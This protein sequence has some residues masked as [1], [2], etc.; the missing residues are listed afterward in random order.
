MQ[1]TRTQLIRVGLVVAGSLMAIGTVLFLIGQQQRL[2]ERKVEYRVRFLRTNGLQVGAPVALTGVTIGS[3][4]S[5]DFPDNPSAQFVV[6]TLSVSRRAAA[7]IKLDAT[8][9]IRTLGLLGDK[10]IELSAG[11]L[12]SPSLAPGA[13]LRAVDPVDYEAVLGQ[14]GDIVSNIIEVTSIMKSVLRAIEQGEGLLG[15]ILRN[16]EAGSEALANF[17][18]T[19]ENLERSTRALAAIAEEVEKG[20]GVLGSLLKDDEAPKEILARLDRA[21]RS[22]EEMANRLTRAQGL[23]PQLLEDEAYGHRLAG[24]L[25]RALENLADVAEKI[26]RGEGTAGQLVNDPTLYRDARKLV[27][28]TQGSWLFGLYRNLQRLW[29]FRADAE[30]HEASSTL[31]D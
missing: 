25:A 30:R 9:S 10:Y 27:S 17:S 6:V 12:E 24:D 13:F 18:R 23:I 14:S 8:A 21:S 1:N 22:I 29:P 31:T 4:S 20:K 3:V 7:R 2:W 26:N 11:S 19:M 5:I 28:D 15:E 16:R